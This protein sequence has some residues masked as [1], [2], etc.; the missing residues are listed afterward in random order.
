MVGLMSQYEHIASLTVL[1]MI[2]KGITTEIPVIS[3][4]ER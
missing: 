4:G 2:H 1:L 3:L